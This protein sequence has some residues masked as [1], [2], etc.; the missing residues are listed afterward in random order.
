[1]CCFRQV[2]QHQGIFWI[3]PAPSRHVS[4]LDAACAGQ[5]LDPG[6]VCHES[7]CRPHREAPD[8][9][10][11]RPH[12]DWH[13]AAAGKSA[14]RHHAGRPHYP[15]SACLFSPFPPE[16]LATPLQPPAQPAK[17]YVGAGRA[18]SQG[19]WLC[20]GGGRC[21]SPGWHIHGWGF[22]ENPAGAQDRG[23]PQHLPFFAETCTSSQDPS[24]KLCAQIE[25][26][27]TL[28]SLVMANENCN[29]LL[30]RSWG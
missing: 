5:A 18:V 7:P 29:R 17:L 14:G 21:R 1:M 8:A 26:L 24:F 28:L 13:A 10:S 16:C 4:M 27:M 3:P 23:P 12:A 25:A 20:P 2:R 11:Q 22:A 15:S 9:A 19:V 30:C 6:S